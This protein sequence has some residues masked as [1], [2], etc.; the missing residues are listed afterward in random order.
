MRGKSCPGSGAHCPKVKLLT[1]VFKCR[2]AKRAIGVFWPVLVAPIQKIEQDRSR[3]NRHNLWS[4][5][6]TT[7]LG[8][9]CVHDARCSIKPK[10]RPPRQ[11][12]RVNLLNGL[13]RSQ[14][15][16][17]PGSRCAAHDTHPAG[18]RR[19]SQKN[20]ASGLDLVILGIANSEPLDIG[21]EVARSSLHGSAFLL[22]ERELIALSFGDKRHRHKVAVSN[23]ASKMSVF[24]YFLLSCAFATLNA[25]RREG[26]CKKP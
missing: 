23:H 4:R 25:N 10:G 8:A 15:I 11:H 2:N 24:L 3:D 17:F 26:G 18:E 9:Q 21:D 5:S 12:K 14:Q 16:G 19:I 6:K 7:P 22:S 13:V 20:C 1:R